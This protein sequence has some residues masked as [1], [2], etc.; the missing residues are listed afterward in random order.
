MPKTRSRNSRRRELPSPADAIRAAARELG[1]RDPGAEFVLKARDPRQDLQYGESLLLVADPAPYRRARLVAARARRG[2]KYAAAV[3]LAAG[4]VE[5]CLARPAQALVFLDRAVRLAPR[6]GWARAWR[7]V[8]RALDA[9]RRRRVDGLR[10]AL[11]DLRKASVLGAPDAFV[12]PWAAELRHDLD[13]RDGALADLAL[14]PPGDPSETWARVERGEILCE[15]GRAGEALEEFSRL[16]A[17]RPGASWAWALRGRTLATA[18]RAAEGLP[19][20]DR[21]VELAPDSAAARAWRS[22]ALRRLGRYREALTDLNRACA[23]EPAYTL[24][25]VW[26][27]RL[28]L[29]LGRPGDA[30]ED[31]DR[32]VRQDARYRLALAWRG[33]ALFKLGRTRDAARDF[34]RVAPL[35]P[36]RSWTPPEREGAVSSPA[37]R[38]AMYWTDLE[39]AASA[40][41]RDRWA[42]RLLDEAR[43]R[44][45]AAEAAA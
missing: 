1:L 33:E 5:A 36:R 31:L 19:D 3:Q 29:I 12:R 20:L 17:E 9:R 35:D 42:R 22:E 44:G 4:A 38:E 32:A 39:G 34:A 25:W 23:L 14:I 18:G 15:S 45:A 40:R 43:A 21:A 37:A 11:A 6:S 30:L 24:A 28:K 8:A 41:P 16:T 10:E 26:R 27:G 7:G 13:D 2:G